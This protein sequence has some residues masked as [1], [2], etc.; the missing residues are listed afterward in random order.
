MTKIVLNQRKSE[1]AVGSRKGISG[2]NSHPTWLQA[3]VPSLKI[4]I[5]EAFQSYLDGVEEIRLRINRPIIFQIGQ[6]ELTLDREGRVTSQLNEGIIISREDLER[7]IRLLSQN[8]IYAWEDEFRS[9]YITIPGGH[10]IG[11]VG[12][13]VLD[14]GILK[15][16]KDI[17]GVNYRIG[18][19]VLGCA[20]DIIPYLLGENKRILH[21]LIISPPQCGK[22]TLLRDIIRQISD[23]IDNLGLSGV[24]VGL[25]D[26]RSE[27]AGMFQGCPQFKIGLRTDVLDACPKA[28]GM[29]MLIRSMSPAVIATDEIGKEEDVEALN[30]ALQAGVSVITT[31]HGSSMEDLQKRPTLKNL[32]G[33]HFFDRL[34]VLSRRKGAG[35]LEGIFDGT[36]LERIDKVV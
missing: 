21:T 29:M 7:T 34:I 14:K 3:M 17:S 2:D 8:S 11:F 26:E 20:Q 23:G 36:T 25:V 15:T 22:T 12:R 33:W 4:L 30:H 32:L 6:R 9:G 5:Q 28:Q 24:N 10:R 27:I 13:G 19:Q 1:V 18:R 31:V 16:L 35:S